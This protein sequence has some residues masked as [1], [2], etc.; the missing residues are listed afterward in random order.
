MTDKKVITIYLFVSL[1]I[2]L[3]MA[4]HSA[5]CITFLMG[6]GLDLFEVNLVNLFYMVAVFILEV[7][8][9][10][11]ADI[12]GRKF[13]F[14]FSGI[15]NGIG[16][17]IYGLA[18]GFLG[19]VVAEIIIALGTTLISGALKAWLVDS[20]HVYNRN[21]GL[22]KVFCL[23]G[24]AINLA[25]VAGGL[26][27]A[28]LGIR[29]LSIPFAITAIGY[30]FLAFFSYAVI[31]EDYFRKGIGQ[32]RS[33][34]GIKEVIKS[35]MIYGFQSDI[36]FLIITVAAIFSLSFRSLNMYRQPQFRSALPGNQYFGFIWAGIAVFT[37]IGNELTRWLFSGIKNKMT[38]LFLGPKLSESECPGFCP[39]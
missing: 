10:A 15:F 26:I 29:D 34:C 2:A 12:W 3:S 33:L 16:F 4:L 23:Q 19:F 21:G 30:W 9:G 6:K 27:G 7:P 20:L 36:I 38:Y 5:I 32:I 8:T 14:V 13:S 22:R 11:V 31:K 37:M 25:R 17:L 18:E 35:G 1:F 39:N 24:R 28:F